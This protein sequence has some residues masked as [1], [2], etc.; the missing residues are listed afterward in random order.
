MGTKLLCWGWRGLL[1]LVGLAVLSLAMLWGLP[2]WVGVHEQPAPA[3]ESLALAGVT[4]VNP[5]EAAQVDVTVLIEDGRIWAVQSAGEAIPA[6]FRRIDAQGRW[7]MPGL[8]DLHVHAFDESDLRLLLAH[9][10]T[11]ARNMLGLP[12][13]LRLRE[14]VQGG[15]LAGARLITAGPTLNGADVPMHSRVSTAEQ[16][17]S[18][19]RES[20]AAGYDLVKV[21]DQIGAEAFAA[22]IDEAG[23]QGMKVAGHLPASVPF[24]QVRQ[25][26]VS[27]EHAEE[28]LQNDLKSASDEAI[29][30]FAAEWATD[31]TPLVAS[32]QIVQRL[33]DIC[34][35]GET[36]VAAHEST[37]LNP[38]VAW[39]G[40]KSLSNFA[41]G[42]EG[43]SEWR[44]QVERMH[45]VVARLHAAGVPI[46]LG[47]DSGPHMTVAGRATLDEVQRLHQAGLSNEDVLRAGTVIAAAVLGKTDELGRIAPGYRADAVL[48]GSDPRSVL[49]TLER[50]QALLA[51]GRW[52][53]AAAHQAL[54]EQG[55]EHAG[56]WLTAGRLFEGL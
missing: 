45:F 32:L 54:L 19:V 1:G 25:A 3:R 16:A 51:D 11:T 50:P 53:D 10:V 7:L 40:R 30:A 38:L 5:G 48:L 9:G 42:D 23:K 17:R 55:G 20:K 8:I 56:W 4:V 31:G 47:S 41:I 6:G 13:H 49:S 22:A 12:M 46:A 44:A 37:D 36:A 43:C 33:S 29:D 28:L 39:L 52:Y 18:A 14:A 2:K 27:I 26:F 35:Q 34:G 15:R 21:Y 24:A